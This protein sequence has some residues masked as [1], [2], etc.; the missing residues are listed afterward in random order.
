MHVLSSVVTHWIEKVSGPWL[1][2]VAAII[3]FAETGTL[4]FLIPGEFTLILAGVAAG[5]GDLNLLVMLVIANAAA[6]LGDATGF[7]IG[8]RY[9]RRLQASWVGQKLGDDN[10]DKAED[11]IRRRRG[12]VVLV[13]RWI[14]FLRAI[15]P[16]SAGMSGM[17]YK[18][19]FLP[20]DLVGAMSWATTCVLLGWKLGDRAEAIVARIGWFAGGAAVLGIVLYIG[21]KKLD[22]RIRGTKKA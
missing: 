7:A 17:N 20:W 6:V 19:D 4:F 22:A 8:R 2:V 5:A 11:L 15:I 21:K 1:Y 18:K 3:T 12:L 16:A 9:G 13:G 14:G 10:W